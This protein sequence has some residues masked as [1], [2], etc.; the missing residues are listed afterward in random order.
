MGEHQVT[1][2]ARAFRQDASSAMKG[3]I[4]RGLVELITNCDDAYDDSTTGKIRIEVEHR[5]SK[6][7]RV[8]VRDRAS[9]MRREKLVTAIGGL[10]GRTSGFEI[11]ANVRGNL[12]RGAK[13]LTAF[14]PVTFESICD[15][16]YSSMVL[17][18]DGTYDA[19]KERQATPDDRERL[20]IPR[21]SGTVVTVV[22]ADNFRCPRHDRLLRTLSQ[23]YQLRDINS[24]PRRE[25]TL[26]DSNSGQNDG[27]RY[28][29][30]SLT[31]VVGLDLEIDGFP[32]AQ[33]ILTIFRNAERYENSSADTCRPEGILIKGTRAI[34]E[35]TLFN[36]ESNVYAHWF[37]GHLVCPYI[38]ELARSYDERFE[39]RQRQDPANPIPIITRGRDGLEGD[40]PFRKALAGAVE[41]VLAE[42]VRKEE[43]QAK[44]GVTTETAKMRRTLDR[45]GQDLGRMVDAD[46][47]EIDED[48]LGGSGDGDDEG[49]IRII[50]ASPVLYVGENKTLS[51]VAH[52]DV[53]VDALDI[54]L[55]PEGVVELL[56]GATVTLEDHPRR[57]DLMI[58]R[59]GLRPLI[60]DDETYFTVRR[61]EL[62]AMAL[63]QVR[64]EREDPEPGSHDEFEFER[65][66][67]HMTLGRRRRLKLYAPV[68]IAN[69][70]GTEFTVQS[71][72][73]GVVPLGGGGSLEFDEE[74]LCYAG[75]VEVDP[76]VLGKRATLTASLGEVTTQCNVVVSQYDRGGPS[77]EIRIVD[78]AGGKYRALVDR[79][80][81]HTV[82]KILG[83]HPAIRRYLGPG[84]D[85]P[86]QD[87]RGARLMIA[88]IV[89][90]EASRIVMEKRFSVSGELDAPAFYSEHLTYMHR[91]LRRCHKM[92]VSDA[93][94]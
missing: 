49:P 27:V 82:I 87:E 1:Y 39:A 7:W 71:S 13:D 17:E 12:G 81:D 30:P 61:G 56:N 60:E 73:S 78:E 29:R 57:D 69:D 80:G 59:I 40:H 68:D 83:G 9:G 31:E 5:R 94:L 16:Y 11:G 44:E 54:E 3:D 48:G 23:H 52:R 45:L 41:S 43:A 47:R 20:G 53:G 6:P 51:V 22:V 74:L 42:L 33:A 14:G 35:N 66:R 28:A 15:K 64:P 88:E 34:Y 36:L 67:Y 65:D 92:M 24:D 58:G 91:Y 89:A 4:V 55:D 32:D 84:P 46:L 37:S 2:A 85:F 79:E 70:C 21:G 10:G 62:E 75:Q 76:R 77:I 26:V 19:P 86:N 18:E 93:E 72:S 25:M 50:P 8:V 63:I 38:D 90:G